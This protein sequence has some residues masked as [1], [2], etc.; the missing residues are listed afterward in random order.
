MWPC[1]TGCEG[2]IPAGPGL[3]LAGEGRAGQLLEAVLKAGD[4]L[5]AS[6]LHLQPPWAHPGCR[7]CSGFKQE[8]AGG[9]GPGWAQQAGAGGCLQNLHSP[10]SN[11]T[12]PPAPEAVLSVASERALLQTRRG[13]GPWAGTGKR[14]PA[15][16]SLRSALGLI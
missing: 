11:E 4:P 9:A 8:Q 13:Q 3:G 15:C 12:S 7:P 14:K 1:Q 6:W 5:G 10:A 16:L 2:L